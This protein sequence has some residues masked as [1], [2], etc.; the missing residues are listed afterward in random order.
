MRSLQRAWFAGVVLALLALGCN[1]KP[2]EDTS[3]G[4]PLTNLGGARPLNGKATSGKTVPKLPPPP[5]LPP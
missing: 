2:G 5:S 1:T 4:P 3:R